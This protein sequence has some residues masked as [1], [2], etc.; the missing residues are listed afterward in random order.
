MRVTESSARMR[1]RAGREEEAIR[2]LTG[3]AVARPHFKQI[4]SFEIPL[5]RSGLTEFQ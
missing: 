4:G 2:D 3:D 1:A 5:A